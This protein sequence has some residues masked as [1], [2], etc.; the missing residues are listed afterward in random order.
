MR[1]WEERYEKL[2]NGEFDARIDE[3]KAKVDASKATREEYKEYEK[4][5]RCKG[6]IGKVQNILD[7]RKKTELELGE[8]NKEIQLRESVKKANEETLKLEIELIQIEKKLE[9]I[10]TQLKDKTLTPEARTQLENRK[11]EV[12]NNRDENNKK[13]AENQEILKQGLNK[14]EKFKNLDDKGLEELKSTTRSR[15]SKC[16]MIA[17]SLVNGLSWDSIDLKLDNW[18]KLTN[19]GK[20]LSRKGKEPEKTNEHGDAHLNEDGEHG[21]AHA[22][23]GEEVELVSSEAKKKENEELIAKKKK[24]A[25]FAAKHPKLARIGNWFKNIF[26]KEDKSLP[27]PTTV[28]TGAGTKADEKTEE[29]EADTDKSFKEYIRYVAEYG[30]KDARKK[31]LQEKFGRPD[32]EPAMSEKGRQSLRAIDETVRRIQEEQNERDL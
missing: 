11:K 18:N 29:I 30:E 10:N 16:N 2:K 15:I 7:Y 13:Y 14:N 23:E 21:D 27:E 25:E 3:L 5:V 22:N 9:N 8:I 4:L 20:K 31:Q 24:Q 28:T 32:R 17:N 1:K 6:N 26:K 12:L 19:K